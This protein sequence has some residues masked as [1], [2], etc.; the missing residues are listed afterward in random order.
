[1]GGQVKMLDNKD[2]KT[3]KAAQAVAGGLKR[4]FG[5]LRWVRR[6][7]EE[8]VPPGFTLPGG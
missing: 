6:R 8:E 7:Q 4:R 1:M 3:V 5:R 2:R